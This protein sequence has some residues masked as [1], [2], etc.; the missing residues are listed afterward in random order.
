MLVAVFG[1]SNVIMSQGPDADSLSIPTV[2]SLEIAASHYITPIII[3]KE[4]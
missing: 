1:P 2:V 3:A 4:F